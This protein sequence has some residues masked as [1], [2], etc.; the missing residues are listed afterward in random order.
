MS[1]KNST[2]ITVAKIGA[3]A[4]IV[5]ALISSATAIVSS[6]VFTPNEVSKQISNLD[7]GKL[8]VLEGWREEKRDRPYIEGKAEASGFLVVL[9]RASV[10]SGGEKLGR[11]TW[12]DGFVDGVLIQSAAA[13][14]A[15][16]DGVSSISAGSFIMPIPKGENW[17]V[18]LRHGLTQNTDVYWYDSVY[19]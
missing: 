4:T 18:E 9:V 14:D 12:V 6:K 10:K 11:L 3:V 15:R 2:T 16:A 19:N 1:S 5:S 17:M 13:Q 8:I 7:S